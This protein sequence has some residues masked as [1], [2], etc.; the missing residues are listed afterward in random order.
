[1][2]LT[3]EEL[4]ELMRAPPGAR[5][6]NLRPLC[7]KANLPYGAIVKRLQ[8]DSYLSAAEL[9]ALTLAFVKSL[10]RS[11]VLRQLE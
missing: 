7:D 3:N 1:M 9:D 11:F 6:I 2:R 5:V 4:K 10:P 8:R